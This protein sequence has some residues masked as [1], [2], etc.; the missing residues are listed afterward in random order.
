MNILKMRRIVINILLIITLNMD[1]FSQSINDTL[2]FVNYSANKIITNNFDAAGNLI[3]KFEEIN[4]PNNTPIN[5]VHIGDSHLQAG[6][7]TEKIKQELFHYYC[8]DSMV[9]PGFIFPFTIARTN[10][11]FFYKVQ[12]TGQWQY[13]KN[14]DYQKTCAIGLSGITVSTNDSSA[15]FSIKMQ[16]KK[17]SS[18]VKTYLFD[19]IILLHNNTG[20]AICKINGREISLENDISK[21]DLERLTD[22]VFVEI[23][24][25][26]TTQFFELYGIV[27]ENSQSKIH[28][29]TIGVNGATAQSYLKCEYFSSHLSYLNPDLI[30]IS[31]GTNEAFDNQ[32]SKLEHEYVLKDII[33]QIQ[34]ILPNAFL[35]LVTPN[36]QLKKGKIN[37]NVS[38]VRDNIL[39]VSR[40]LHLGYWDFYA[41]MGSNNSINEWYN[42]G[43]TGEDKLHLNPKGYR[44]QGELFSK[45]IINFIE[46]TK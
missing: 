46:Q 38:Q 29:H 41:V 9:S 15:S 39:K 45:A 3:K 12:Y 7:L 26:D 35:V 42:A 32:F 20:S 22:S 17:D 13:G 5:I 27:L 4:T 10:N 14:I 11:P 25:T 16:N 6:F 40:E 21:I 37:K 34:D 44:I 2:P 18:Y 33:F 43:L 30:I 1:A 19:K 36:D 31:L 24:N 23:L 8:K 28:Y